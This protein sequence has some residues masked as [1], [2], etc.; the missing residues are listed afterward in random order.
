VFVV[1]SVSKVDVKKLK[2]FYAE[3]DGGGLLMSPVHPDIKDAVRKVTFIHVCLDLSNL[4]KYW[5]FLPRLE[6]P[7]ENLYVS[8]CRSLPVPF[9]YLKRFF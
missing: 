5:Q 7:S 3:D 6:M 8:H 1:L 2:V 4:D 9:S